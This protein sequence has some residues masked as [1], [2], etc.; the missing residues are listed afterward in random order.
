MSAIDTT[1]EQGQ[2][3]EWGYNRKE[4]VTPIEF[5]REIS[6]TLR[7]KDILS[8]GEHHDME[9]DESYRWIQQHAG[10]IIEAY[11]WYRIGK[12]TG[13][14]TPPFERLLKPESR[15]S[16]NLANRQQP[17]FDELRHLHV[18][19]L[20]ALGILPLARAAGYTDLVLEGFDDINP[21]RTIQRSKDKTGD[22]LRIVSAMK[23]GMRIH[24]AWPDKMFPMPADIGDA[25]FDKIKAAKEANP[26]AK[27]I[28][29]NG[30]VHNMTEPF[31]AG[32]KVS[33]GFF[34]ETDA[35]EWTYAPRA[36]ALWGDRYGAIDILNGN[37]PLPDSHYK[38]MQVK[39]EPGVITRFSHGFDQQTFVLK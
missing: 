18:G 22:L 34:G 39:A 38:F 37:R 29:Y 20:F 23:L 26:D 8:V 10:E 4:V 21:A 11:D 5:L 25:L 16:E 6:D 33:L 14:H 2:T 1:G 12:I 15:L 30:A 31:R 17:T 19:R 13:K 36:R 27:I 35:S 9:Q 32:T 3:Q 7:R 28:V 24:G